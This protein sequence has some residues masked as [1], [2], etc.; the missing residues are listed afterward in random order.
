[1]MTTTHFVSLCKI[2][3]ASIFEYDFIWVTVT[4]ILHVKFLIPY[5]KFD[6][7]MPDV[8]MK[9]KKILFFYKF[10]SQTDIIQ[11]LFWNES[12]TR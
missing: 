9:R 10:R 6:K 2:I 1:M 3:L 7:N 4:D 8:L 5:V 12:K 11:E